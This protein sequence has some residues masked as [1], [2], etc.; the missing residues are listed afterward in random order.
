MD[1]CVV[2]CRGIGWGEVR[3]SLRGELG[4]TYLLKVK[5]VK[6][7]KG[8]KYVIAYMLNTDLVGYHLGYISLYRYK[9]TV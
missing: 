6:G 7:R 3:G 5:A 8:A 9:D 4:K 1:S 2:P